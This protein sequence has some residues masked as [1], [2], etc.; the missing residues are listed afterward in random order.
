MDTFGAHRPT[1]R[2]PPRVSL[3]GSLLDPLFVRVSMGDVFRFLCYDYFT[4]P[5]LKKRLRVLI[6]NANNVVTSVRILELNAFL[7]V[8]VNTQPKRCPHFYPSF[9][10]DLD[11]VFPRHLFVPRF[12]TTLGSRAM[13]TKVKCSCVPTLL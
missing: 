5:R 9:C 1:T 12:L 3:D 8:R 4:P 13:K 2:L 6:N 11:P 10:S 7:D